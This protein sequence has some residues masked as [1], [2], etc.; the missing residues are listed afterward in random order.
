MPAP[1][2]APRWLAGLTGYL[3]PRLI[4]VFC[5]GLS[6]GFPLT[7]ILA[8]LTYW[9]SKE[10]VSKGEV[11]LFSALL[12]PYSLKFLWAPMIDRV[13]LPWLAK[14]VGQRRAWLFA[15]QALLVLAILGLGSGDPAHDLGLMAVC[16]FAVALASASQDIVIDAFRI[17][18]LALDDQ[19]QGAAMLIFGYRTGNLIAGAGAVALQIAVGWQVT[20]YAMALLVLVGAGAAW[21]LGEPARHDTHE[22]DAAEGRARAWLAR[23][24]ETPKRQ[25][26]ILAWLYAT[27]V[28]PFQEF[29]ARPYAWAILAFVLIY[30][31]GDAMGQVMLSPLVVELGFSDADYIWA[32]KLVGFWALLLGTALG[33]GAVKVLGLF[34]ALL[35]TG[36]LM[37]AT[38]LLFAVLALAGDVPAM[39]AVAVGFENFATG[40]GLSVFVAYLSGLCNL[41]YTATH[42][43][44][45]SA[46][47]TTARNFLA[48]PSG[49]LVEAV[50]WPAFYV[51]TTVVALP[52]LGLLIWLWRR[53]LQV[54]PEASR[55]QSAAT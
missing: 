20:Y 4:G 28:A 11:G 26:R 1:Q 8:T 51:I 47:A 16:A 40:I 27:V 45:L 39:L 50:G 41:A 2:P 35:V 36:V 7:L 55:S 29:L 17:E 52:G 38:N 54:E 32:N 13:P 23:R 48:A 3:R 43:A 15:T 9:L 21:A 25:A 44:L 18:T 19:G 30:K 5:L 22:A 49:Y 10:G 14:R 37:M 6:S 34:R 53:G 46:L 12:I 24:T 31:L 42:Y 33:G